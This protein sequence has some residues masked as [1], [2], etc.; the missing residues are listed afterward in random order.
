MQVITHPEDLSSDIK[1]LRETLLG[2]RES[3]TMEKRYIHKNGQT[4]YIILAVSVVK[5]SEGGILYLVTQIVDITAQK[6][7][8]IQLASTIA[9]NQAIMDASSQ[10]IMIGSNT[11]GI[12]TSF[13][14][15]A[16]QLL[17]YKAEELIN[18]KPTKIFH[19]LEE[20]K[21][22]IQEHF[23]ETGEL[24]KEEDL[25]ISNAKN[26]KAQTKEWTFVRKDGR[27]FPVLL[28]VT[29]IKRKDE[30]IG[31]LAIG[32]DITQIKQVEKETLSLLAIADSQNER[33]KNFAYIVSHNL[34]SHSGGISTLIEM[35]ETEFP[36]FSQT[37]F[38]NYLKKSSINLS[39]TIKHLTDVVQIN[40]STQKK[41]ERIA[42][43]PIIENN[44]NSLI[45]QANN[46]KIRIINEVNPDITVYAIPAYLDSIVMNF[47]TNAIKY[48]GSERDS[49]LKIQTEIIDKY[50]VLKF[51]DNGL[52]IDLNKHG[53]KLFGMYKTFHNHPDSRGIGLFISKNQVESMN[54]KIEVESEINTGTTFKIY[55]D[56]EKN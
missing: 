13:N 47:I 33:L 5:N 45:M 1:L 35:I 20:I 18:K 3:Y 22:S 55:L 24:L 52:G 51:I 49:Y 42:L 6:T 46:Q 9:Y 26:G 41:L 54:G 4:I 53:S 7:T 10:V 37:D 27:T 16:E 38:F 56:N 8:E 32:T 25:F 21:N 17:G 29:A 12:I 19:I 11:T 28:S 39:E 44:I 36:D 30:I 15:G 31:Y 40:L 23:E 34:R 2:K 50:V 48:S 14:E 43:K